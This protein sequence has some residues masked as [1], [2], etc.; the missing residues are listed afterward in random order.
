MTSPAT[1][2]DRPTPDLRRGSDG[3]LRYYL[4]DERVS[5]GP[6]LLDEDEARD[7]AAWLLRVHATTPD[8]ESSGTLTRLLAVFRRG[9]T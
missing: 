6:A 3:M 4:A 8:A 5:H 1:R 2:S 7:F 9:R